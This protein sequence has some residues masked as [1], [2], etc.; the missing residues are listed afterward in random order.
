MSEP[1]TVVNN[2]AAHRFEAAIGGE[3]AL[4]AYR[5]DDHRIAFTHT[6]VPEVFQGRGIANI[7]AG[8]A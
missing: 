4:I 2:E 7:M 8:G 3:I 5:R 6:E 1:I